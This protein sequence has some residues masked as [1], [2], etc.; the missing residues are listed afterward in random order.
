MGAPTSVYA[1]RKDE[2]VLENI[3]VV[4]STGATVTGLV[5]ANFN[6][7]L[8]K[9]GA[10]S[11]VSV[12]VTEINAVT[13]PGLY[14]VEFVPNA[15]GHWSL[16]VNH[17]THNPEGWLSS[18]NVAIG[19]HA[20]LDYIA[21]LDVPNAP[22][23]GTIADIVNLLEEVAGKGYRLDWTYDGSD[24]V[25]SVAITTS[26]DSFTTTHRSYTLTYTYGDSAHPLRPT[27]SQKV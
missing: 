18:W 4:D 10:V 20:D 19:D 27:R 8:L 7:W 26:Q 9:D 11:A 21:A 13:A 15:T 2:T 16:R 1:Y 14:K 6:K 12:T 23:A 5:N 22:T 17:A 24:R 25:S 3:L